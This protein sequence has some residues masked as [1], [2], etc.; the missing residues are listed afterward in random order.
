MVTVIKTIDLVGVSETS[1]RDA[2]EFMLLGSSTVQVCTAIMHH[3]FRIIDDLCTGLSNYCDERGLSSVRELIGVAKA[4]PGKLTYGS[5]GTGAASHLSAELFKSMA[6]IEAVHIPYKGTGPAYI[7]LIGGRIHFLISGPGAAPFV[8]NG[9]LKAIGTTSL[10]RQQAYPDL[11]TFDESGVRG[12]ETA[13]WTALFAPAGTPR[14]VIQKLNAEI[15]KA[16]ETTDLKERLAQIG[17]V[18]W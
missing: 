17:A 15:M 8:K 9:R 5:S 1:W 13:L 18:T 10:K 11:P 4:N 3:G 2:A 12:F 6:G 14:P 16:L 7:D